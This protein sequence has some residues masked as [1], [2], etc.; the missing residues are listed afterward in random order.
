VESVKAMP[1]PGID[2]SDF[3]PYRGTAQAVRS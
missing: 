1:L 2:S 3:V